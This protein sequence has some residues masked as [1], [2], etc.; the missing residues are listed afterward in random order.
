M[1]ARTPTDARPA[2]AG[3]ENPLYYLENIETVVEWV[4]VYHGDLLTAPERQR[5]ADFR[6]L[7]TPARALLT[8]MI[9]RTGDLFRVDKLRYPEVEGGEHRVIDHLVQT[10]WLDPA[11]TVSLPELFRL[12]TLA[13]LRPVFADT[14][15]A[16]G[17][18]RTLPKGQML[19]RLQTVYH[20]PRSVL[21]WLGGP[22]PVVRLDC[23]ALFDRIR[24]MFFGNLRQSW[25]DFV[26][27]ELGHQRYETVRFTPDSRAFAS[28]EEV[29]LYLAMDQCRQRLDDGVALGDVW[30]AVPPPSDNRWLSRRRDRLLLEL[31]RV[32]E[33]SGDRDLALQAFAAS[34][35]REASL[36]RLRLLERL[37]RFDEAWIIAQRW[38]QQA[39]SD[40]EM[41]GLTRLLKRL[42]P[43]V[44]HPAPQAP[45]A[46]AIAAHTLILP[47]PQTGSVEYAVKQQLWQD[48]APVYYVENTLINALFGLLCWDAIYQ[49][50]PGAFF[51]PFH[52]GPA[53]LTGEDF[54]ARR[55]AAFDACL[56]LLRHGNHG[57]V[58]RRNFAAKQGITNPFVVWPVIQQELLDMAL[59]CLPASD[60]DRIFRRLMGN[61]REHRS[62]LP[63]LIQFFP[64]R[65]EGEA[66]YE[67]IEVKGPGDRLQDHQIRWLE[68]FAAEGIPARVCYVRWHDG[69]APA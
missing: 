60:L 2:S 49:P 63:D 59:R 32:A 41:Q 11:P 3:L 68:F 67:M 16:L 69:E 45:A 34:G 37:K 38:Q 6:A 62:G 44:G 31:G 23:M 36:K 42:G 17:F 58:I 27:V 7:P 19:D 14:L 50:L 10:E 53:D 47:K 1:P 20:A 24:L 22:A 57:S 26:L 25:S 65:P 12:F 28:R 21:E 51:H 39:L 35:H 4:T 30:A 29:D 43:K 18:P 52:V 56:D 54:I 9:M 8:R 48:D 5:L 55:A 33:R 40:A 66:C 13:E 46:A 15:A 61:L 64:N